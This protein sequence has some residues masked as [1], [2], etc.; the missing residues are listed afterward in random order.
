M[1]CKNC[2]AEYEDN[3]LSCPY[4]H[5]ENRKAVNRKKKEILNQYDKEA[6]SIRAQAETYAER[7]ANNMT[8]KIFIILG[9]L[10]ACGIVSAIILIILSNFRVNYEYRQKTKHVQQLE[11]MLATADY[12][13]MEAYLRERNLFSGYDKYQQP[14]ELY[15]RYLRIK[16]DGQQIQSIDMREEWGY[17]KWKSLTEYYVEDIL[18]SA[19]VVIDDYQKYTMDKEFLG[20]EEVLGEIYLLVA[21]ELELYGFTKE[22][23][24]EIELKNQGNRWNELRDRIWEY[25][26]QA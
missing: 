21:E 24:S 19:A 26:W 2:G 11:E 13:G 12:A 7:T 20:N 6:A 15:R 14:A 22:D 4:C 1:I 5:T 9:I 18:D 8:R 3:R 23:L 16:E 17:E 10:A 25:Y